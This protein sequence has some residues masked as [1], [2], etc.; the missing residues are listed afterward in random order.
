MLATA[1]AVL[2]EVTALF[3]RRPESVSAKG[4]PGERDVVSS[5]D[6][7]IEDRARAFLADRTAD[8]GFLGEE[9]GHSG[10]R[11]SFWVLDPVD[12]TVNYVRGAPLCGISLAL[13]EDGEPV[14]GVIAL[15]EQGRRYWAIA[16]GGAHRD[17]QRIQAARTRRLRD[18][19]I[20]LGDY[21]TG[22][23][24]H[25]SNQAAF[26][27]DQLLAAR[28]QRI[29]RL[30]SAAVDLAWVADGTVDASITLSNRPWDMASG[31]VIA[32]EAGALVLDIDGSQHST[33]SRCTLALAPHLADHLVPLIQEAA[34][35]TQC[36][37]ITPTT[38]H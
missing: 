16:G 18:S 22:P 36:G 24:A 2:D 15:P 8:R 34:S 6:W 9:G 29:R 31:T 7:A 14:L 10:S 19:V 25:E 12:G 28:V 1:H 35:H 30:G 26:A 11:E 4:V 27:L 37:P 21:H 32:R 5:T 20:A 17:G 13:V 33:A 38:D 23:G 3:L